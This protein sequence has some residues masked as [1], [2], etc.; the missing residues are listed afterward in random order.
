MKERGHTGNYSLLMKMAMTMVMITMMMM[1]I[2]L[3]KTM[4]L[5]VTW[6]VLLIGE[7]P[8]TRETSVVNTLIA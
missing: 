4:T 7:Y 8:T 5:T 3:R 6:T 2:T 1:M